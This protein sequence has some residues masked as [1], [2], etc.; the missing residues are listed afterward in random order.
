MIVMGIFAN[1]VVAMDTR[2]KALILTPGIIAGGAQY[3]TDTYLN[4]PT[5]DVSEKI[6]RAGVV[7][8]GTSGVGLMIN[9]R[10][11]RRKKQ[12]VLNVDK[13]KEGQTKMAT[14]KYFDNTGLQEFVKRAAAVMGD[15]A[16]VV[17]TK[18]AYDAY[19][20][21]NELPEEGREGLTVSLYNQVKPGMDKV[22]MKLV[23]ANVYVDG[24]SEKLASTLKTVGKKVGKAALTGLS[25]YDTASTVKGVVDSTRD[26][27]NR[28][29]NADNK[30]RNSY[31]TG[32]AR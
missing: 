23:A 17:P 27:L 14:T 5:P 8:V 9:K 29:E 19:Q 15:E 13:T 26:T 4:T 31:S 28:A 24:G 32:F 20:V 25:V 18:Y 3:I 2:T 6:L 11:E 30:Q 22:A 12:L 21:Y 16:Y 1:E 10:L 7:G